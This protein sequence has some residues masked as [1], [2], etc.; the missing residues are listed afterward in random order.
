MSLSLSLSYGEQ[1][2]HDEDLSSSASGSLAFEN[3]GHRVEESVVAHVSC[4]G[5]GLAPGMTLAYFSLVVDRCDYA[6]VAE[7]YELTGASAGGVVV[8]VVERY[9][10]A[11][12]S[13][14]GVVVV[15][16]VAA[17]DGVGCF[18]YVLVASSI[19]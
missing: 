1:G 11:A 9:K 3:P 7:R 8:V 13:A 5:M 16:S 2:D 6:V 12:A 10:L 18:D 14:G 17:A 4:S 19:A 15:V